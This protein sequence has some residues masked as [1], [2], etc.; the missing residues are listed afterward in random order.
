MASCAGPGDRRERTFF[1]FALRP[2]DRKVQPGYIDAFD[3]MP[4]VFGAFRILVGKRVTDMPSGGIRMALDNR[5]RFSHVVPVSDRT[6]PALGTHSSHE[7]ESS[8]PS[9]NHRGLHLFRGI[10]GQMA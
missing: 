4:S 5:D 2:E 10:S 3:L 1:K 9:H 6:V 7:F 8:Q